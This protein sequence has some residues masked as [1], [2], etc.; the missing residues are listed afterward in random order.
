MLSVT[1]L[2]G[3]ED[4]ITLP[5]EIALLPMLP[6][7]FTPNGDGDNDV[8]RI[9][10]GPFLSVD[11]RIYNN[12]G[13]QIFQTNQLEEGWDGTYLGDFVQAGVY[14]WTFSVQIIG[15]KIINGTG[16]VTLIK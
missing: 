7:G 15:G 13:E 14:T 1:D 8:F 3:C 6:T 2:N 12:W 5:L 10:G 4:T 16:D 11:F 9:R